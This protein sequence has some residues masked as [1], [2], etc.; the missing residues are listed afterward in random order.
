LGVDHNNPD[1]ISML[2]KESSE[3]LEN[4]EFII[5]NLGKPKKLSDSVLIVR[6]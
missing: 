1:S 2:S 6:C 4:E 3:N 5:T